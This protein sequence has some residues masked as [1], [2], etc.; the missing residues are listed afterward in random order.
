MA[1]EYKGGECKQ[2][3]YNKCQAALQF[4]HINPDVKAFN[5]S[6]DHIRSWERLKIELDKCDLLCANCHAE[7]HWHVAQ[8]L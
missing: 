8:G 7:M 3:G 5:V 1:I 6:H 4:H 2:C